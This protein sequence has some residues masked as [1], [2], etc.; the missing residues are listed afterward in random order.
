MRLDFGGGAIPD[1]M[2]IW[3][4]QSAAITLV[5]TSLKD[6]SMIASYMMNST[7]LGTVG[8]T[9]A[10]HRRSDVHKTF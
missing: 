9:I 10:G 2:T 4:D 3:S 8:G 5:V 1:D 7:I 6:S